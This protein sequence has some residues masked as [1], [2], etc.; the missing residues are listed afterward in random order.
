MITVKKIRVNLDDNIKL[1]TDYQDLIEKDCKRGHRLLS[2]REKEKLNTV[3]DIC[4]TIKRGSDRELDQCL[5]QRSNLENWS[6]KYG[7]R[8][9]KASDIMRDYKELS[10]NKILQERDKEEQKEQKKIEKAKKRR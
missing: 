2:Q 8:S 1:E 7:T 10:G 5:P 6:D 3:I 9:K 4:K